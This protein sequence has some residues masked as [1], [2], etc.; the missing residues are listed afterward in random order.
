M[1]DS[2]MIAHYARK[3]NIETVLYDDD[4]LWSEFEAAWMLCN[5]QVTE[6]LR[7]RP[8]G[9]QARND[10]P[11]GQNDE[12]PEKCDQKKKT[13]AA[14]KQSQKAAARRAD[15]KWRQEVQGRARVA[16]RKAIVSGVEAILPAPS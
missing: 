2:F 14:P 10:I 15:K 5:Q 4:R 8:C 12:E 16:F 11:P 1:I 7:P 6:A 13:S 3:Q 9:D